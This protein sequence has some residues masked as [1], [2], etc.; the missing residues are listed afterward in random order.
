MCLWKVLTS[1]VICMCV[2]VRTYAYVFSHRLLGFLWQTST[3]LSVKQGQNVT[4][5]CSLKTKEN[6][7]VMTWYK[8]NPG[9]GVQMLLSYN[10]SVPPHVHYTE[11]INTHRYVVLP[12]NR[13]RAHHRLR[14][15][16][17]EENDTATY[18]CGYSEKLEGKKNM[19]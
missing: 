16:S 9:Y 6:I 1:I 15:I 17:A 4:L 7:G 19:P 8:Q 2:C 14:I 18:Y 3:G 10:I 11:G 12:R 13:P 5:I